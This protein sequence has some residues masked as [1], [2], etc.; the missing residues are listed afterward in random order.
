MYVCM[1]VCMRGKE[2]SDL[3][4][5]LPKAT[6]YIAVSRKLLTGKVKIASHTIPKI[7]SRAVSSL[8]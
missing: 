8:T 4:C 2:N 6:G 1:Y 3:S 5:S 7:S